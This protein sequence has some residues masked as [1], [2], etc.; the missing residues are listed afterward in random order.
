MTYHFKNPSDGIVK[1]YLENSKVI[2]VVGLSDREEATSHR[3]SK[4]MQERGYRIVPVNP[5]AAG[6]QILGETVYATIARYGYERDLLVIVEGFYE[7]DIYRQML[8]E[9]RDLFYPKVLSYY[10]DLIFEETVRRH[11]TRSKKAD[12]SPADMKRWW[13]ERDFLRLGSSNLYRSRFA[14]RRLSRNL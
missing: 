9:L 10:Y 4:E 12:F 5:R 3:V 2:A 14:G 1:H 7:T 6:G 11:Q 13:K 8:E